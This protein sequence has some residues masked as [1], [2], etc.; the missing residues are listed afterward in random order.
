MRIRTS[1][2]ASGIDGYWMMIGGIKESIEAVIKSKV[3]S[4][5]KL[6]HKSVAYFERYSVGIFFR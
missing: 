6:V 2:H 1:A 4:G 3:K 5:E